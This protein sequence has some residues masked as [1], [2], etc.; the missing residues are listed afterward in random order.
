MC[1]RDPAVQA[2]TSCYILILER[3]GES[4]EGRGRGIEKWGGGVE[5]VKGKRE[6]LRE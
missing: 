2:D 6:R 3:E 4:G 1:A 5:D